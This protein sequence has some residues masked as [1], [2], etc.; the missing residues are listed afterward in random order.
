MKCDFCGANLTIDDVRCPHC[1]RL[2]KHYVAHRQEMYRY[3]Q[4][5]LNTKRN[6]YQKAGK[7]SKRMTRIAIM[8]VMTALCLGSVILNFF[9]YSIRNMVTNYSVKQNLALHIENLDNYIQQEGWIGY[10]AYVD[11]NNIYYCEENELK[12]YK[13]FSRVTRSYDYIYEYCMRVVGNKNSGDESN[14]YNTDRCIDEIADYLNDMYTFADGGKYDE[15]VDFNE[16]HKNWCDSL[17]EQTEELLQ[18]YMGVDSR[19]IASGEIR[20]LSKGELIVVLEGSY[21]QNEL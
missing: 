21:K 14:W 3:K 19:M 9:S 7:I 13:D 4:D 10:E 8:A 20:K 6:V 2:N 11:A 15:Y 5:Y 16:N 17:M 12:D 18:A 1:N